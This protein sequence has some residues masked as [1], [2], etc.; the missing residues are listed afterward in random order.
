MMACKWYKDADGDLRCGYEP[1]FP[2]GDCLLVGGD[3]SPQT[4]KKFRGDKAP[5][6]EAFKK[7]YLKYRGVFLYPFYESHFSD[8]F[9]Q[10]LWLFQSTTHD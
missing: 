2:C 8:R 4:G 1:N 7:T 9:C 10:C 5:Y 3:I 6:V